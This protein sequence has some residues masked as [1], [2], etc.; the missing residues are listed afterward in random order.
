MRAQPIHRPLS[1][2]P[3]RQGATTS[4]YSSFVR[5]IA[6]DWRL[7]YH[8]RD[9]LDVNALPW[10]PDAI[11]P[12]EGRRQVDSVEKQHAWW[13]SLTAQQRLEASRVVDAL[14]GWMADSLSDFGI[15]L[16]E[17]DLTGHSHVFL[18]PTH[19]REFIFEQAVTKP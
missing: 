16:V 12:Q 18:M 7:A 11:A 17:A 8:S 19:V 6:N 1:G 15:V 9:H 13:N 3:L 10:T 14:P 4:R 5:D 2:L